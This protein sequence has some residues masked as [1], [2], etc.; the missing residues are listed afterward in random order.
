[1]LHCI[2]Y[3]L[4]RSF[5]AS[6]FVSRDCSYEARL[7]GG[8]SWA[9]VARQPAWPSLCPLH[10]PTGTHC[11]KCWK[12][13]SNGGNTHST[14]FLPLTVVRYCLLIFAA[15]AAL[16][17]AWWSYG[18]IYSTLKKKHGY[19]CDE[20]V[21]F[22]DDLDLLKKKYITS[23]RPIRAILM[24]WNSQPQHTWKIETI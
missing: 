2:I 17:R 20:T 10:I 19:Q 3:A 21:M 6:C 5:A 13:M 24:G 7:S 16:F 11:P 14:F 1:M 4:I 23:S 22:G 12:Q 18:G 9:D 15:H 8:A